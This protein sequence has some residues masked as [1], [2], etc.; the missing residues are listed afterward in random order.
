MPEDDVEGGFKTQ[1]TPPPSVQNA[2]IVSP[3]NV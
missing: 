2:E 3:L 1:K